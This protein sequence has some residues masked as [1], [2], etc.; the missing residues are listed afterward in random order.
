MATIDD[1]L[2]YLLRRA[3][4]EAITA[5]FGDHTPAGAAHYEMSVRYSAMAVRALAKPR[6][7]QVAPSIAVNANP[8]A[9]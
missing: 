1:D 8:P 7:E 6:T 3:E 9:D 5:I 4:Q 2:P